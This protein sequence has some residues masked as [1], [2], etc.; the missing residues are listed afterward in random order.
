MT[1]LLER[2]SSATPPSRPPRGSGRGRR[3]RLARAERRERRWHLGG[4]GSSGE[5]PQPSRSLLVA[6]VLASATLATL[7]LSTGSHSPLEPVRGAVADVVGPFESG[8][9]TIVRP[10]AG[11]PDWFRSRSTLSDQVDALTQE[12]QQLR[13]ELNAAPYDANRLAEYDKLTAAASDLGT[14]LLPARVIGYGPAQSFSS[15]VTL[16]AGSDAGLRPD[17][18]VVN[19]DG[20]VGRILRTSRSTSTVLL[21]TDPDSTVGARVG[22]TLAMGFLRGRGVLGDDGRLDLELVDDSAVPARADTVVTWGS[23]GGAPYVAGVPI[24]RVTHVYS[25]VRETSQRI[26]VDPYVDFG[27]LDVVGVVVPTGTQ[28]DRALIGA[29]GELGGQS[30]AGEAR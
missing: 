15:T 6:L 26:V 30:A 19:G 21:I 12:N 24:G 29:D 11:V 9:S 23:T 1:D 2:P 25:S 8:T 16:D 5:R 20:L 13:S 22:D 4:L 7:D 17:M 3:S 27:A 28:S 10:L 18:T 14:S